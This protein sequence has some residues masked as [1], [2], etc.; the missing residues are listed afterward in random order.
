MLTPLLLACLQTS[1]GIPL[2]SLDLAAV[3]QEWG[4]PQADKSVE[5]HPLVIGGKSFEKGL[6]THANS[7]LCV[8]LGAAATR[9]HAFVGAD[10]ETLPRKGSIEFRVLG[11]GKELWKSGVLH[12]GDAAKEVS[13][14]LAGVKQLLLLVEDA[15]D[16]I[17]CDHADWALATIEAA[18]DAK[19]ASVVPPREEPVVL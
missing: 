6:G 3:E 12:T 18:G 19:I 11:D 8:D 15:G 16:G 2:A 14:P 10:D 7:Q 9:F 4:Q 5:K 1:T 13:V 17:S